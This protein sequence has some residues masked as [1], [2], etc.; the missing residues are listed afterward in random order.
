MTAAKLT[1]FQ[2]KLVRLRLSG[3]TLSQIAEHSKRRYGTVRNDFMRI[4]EVLDI[5]LLCELSSAFTSYELGLGRY[6]K[7]IEETRNLLEGE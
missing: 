1:P 5:H 6:K 2:E 7:S 3:M 4:Y